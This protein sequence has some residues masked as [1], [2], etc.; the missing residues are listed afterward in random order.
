VLHRSS[1]CMHAV[2]ITPVESQS[3][4][5]NLFLR[6]I[7]LPQNLG[8]SASTSRLS[9]PAQRS[10]TLRP[11]YSPSHSHAPLRRRLQRFVTVTTAP[12]AT[13]LERKLTGGICTRWK[14]VPSHRAQ[15]ILRYRRPSV[16]KVGVVRRAAWKPRHGHTGRCPP[17][18]SRNPRNRTRIGTETVQEQFTEPASAARVELRDKDRLSRGKLLRLMQICKHLIQKCSKSQSTALMVTKATRNSFAQLIAIGDSSRR[19]R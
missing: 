10:L 18:L 12:I 1:S 3:A 7:S 8:G 5:F 16:P 19:V 9:R 15:E 6:G 11:A 14:T 13:G 17:L 2:A 4:S